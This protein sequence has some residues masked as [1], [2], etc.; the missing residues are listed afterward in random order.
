M[1]LVLLYLVE[2]ILSLVGTIP[3]VGTH[4][5][6][7]TNPSRWNPLLQVGTHFRW[8]SSLYVELLPLD[9]TTF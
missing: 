7:G 6:V 8:K 4:P 5:L 2:T 3:L 9:G 1:S